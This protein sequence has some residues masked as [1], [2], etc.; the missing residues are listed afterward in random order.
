MTITT[1]AANDRRAGPFTATNGQTTF[2]YDF[3]IYDDADLLVLRLRDDTETPLTLGDDY[4]VTGV[5][6]ATGGTIELVTGADLDDEITILGALAP[7]RATEFVDGGELPAADLNTELNRLVIMAQERITDADEIRVLAEAAISQEDLNEAVGEISTAVAASAS[8]AEDAADSAANAA[9]ALAALLSGGGLSDAPVSPAMQAVVIAATLALARA[10]LGL[11][12]AATADSGDFQ[13]AGLAALKANN[14]SDLANAATART[15][16]GL[17]A[18]A[19]TGAGTGLEV[20]GGNTRLT[21]TGATAAT[22]GDAT[23]ALQVTVDAKG[24]ITAISAVEIDVPAGA[25]ELISSG[26]GTSA[27]AAV[28]IALPA[29]YSRYRLE[30]QDIAPATAAKL[31]LRFSTDSGVSYVAT[32]V[33]DYITSQDGIGTTSNN[34]S[35]TGT[36]FVMN[37]TNAA[38]SSRA[39]GTIDIDLAN[40]LAKSD[41]LTRSASE[42]LTYAGACQFGGSGTISHVRLMFSSGNVARYKYRLT[43]LE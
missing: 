38:T 9:A 34:G 36:A 30:V 12:S 26:S 5:A 28:D 32:G 8:S 31:Q 39:L 33:Y 42:L 3:P 27:V 21:D 41:F 25:W 11:G 37:E 23:H 43:G 1:I 24:R 29:G 2:S 10:A 19:V 40:K 20:S 7:V 35:T 18:L 14:L 16:L 22:Y 17:G 15:N 13:T 4:T 6:E